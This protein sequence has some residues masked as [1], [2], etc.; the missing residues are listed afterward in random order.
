MND[1]K[2]VIASY[3]YGYPIR[4]IYLGLCF[5]LLPLLLFSLFLSELLLFQF[6]LLDDW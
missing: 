4:S 1:Y 5:P 3:C 2:A 6:L